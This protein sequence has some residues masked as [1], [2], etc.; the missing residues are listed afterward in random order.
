M[1]PLK[2]AELLYVRIERGSI[3]P[4]PLPHCIDCAKQILASGIRRVWM[5]HEDGWCPYNAQDFYIKTIETLGLY[6]GGLEES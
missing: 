6:R 1:R 4:G 2:T 3:K 5:Y